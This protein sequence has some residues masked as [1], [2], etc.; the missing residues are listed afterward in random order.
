MPPGSDRTPHLTCIHID[1][2]QLSMVLMEYLYISSPCLCL[3]MNT[4]YIWLLLK[5]NIPVGSYAAPPAG[6]R[7]PPACAVYRVPHQAIQSPPPTTPPPTTPRQHPPPFCAP[8]DDARAARPGPRHRGHRRA[9]RRRAAGRGRRA[10]ELEQPAYAV[11]FDQRVRRPNSD[12]KIEPV[13][14]CSHA[15]AATRAPVPQR[16][17]SRAVSVRACT[18]PP[19]RSPVMGGLSTSKITAHPAAGEVNFAGTVRIVPKLHA[20]VR[21]APRSIERWTTQSKAKA[22]ERWTTEKIK[23]T[24]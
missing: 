17:L 23:H 15:H 12:P 9:S 16:S 14:S 2:P 11:A 8:N 19:S 21:A 7:P 20:P 10:G 3:F 22:I 6:G 5:V 1:I 18:A 4:R 24:E 13:S